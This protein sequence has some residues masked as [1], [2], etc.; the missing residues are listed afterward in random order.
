MSSRSFQTIASSFLRLRT[1]LLL[2]GSV[3]SMTCV[4]VAGA[5]LP[6]DLPSHIRRLTWFGERADWSLDGKRILFV[7]KTFGDVYEA[8]V[9]TGRISPV[10][11]HYPHAGY[12]RALYLSN[13]DI[14]LSGPE[15]FEPHQPGDARTHCV[16]SVLDRRR[17]RPPVSLGTKCSEGPTASRR[18]LRIAWTHVSAQYPDE[19][20]KGSSRIQTADVVFEN[21]KPRLAN[22][23]VV[24]ES[25]SLAF[26]CT[27]EVQN[28]RPPAEQE[29]TFSTYGYDG[30][31]VFGLDLS[32][33]KTRNYSN[34]PD[35]YDEVEGIFPDGQHTL[36]ECDRDQAQKG[37]RYI[38]LWKLRLDGSGHMMRVTR[39]GE[40]AGLKGS[41]G[42]VSDDGRFLAFQLAR[43]SDAAGVGYGIFILNL[44]N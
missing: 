4:S 40:T 14:L 10:T 44:K 29:L 34:A 22:L 5:D 38:D 27:L 37:W 21:A 7:E 23:K 15:R 26:S 12:T 1:A 36:V 16:L 31:E 28:F 17:D 18:H 30:T 8:E 2:A 20:T 13:G 24:L 33:G 41:N 32:T 39:F 3:S 6:D 9:A 43:S 35:Q 11:H 25:K 42:V 19:M